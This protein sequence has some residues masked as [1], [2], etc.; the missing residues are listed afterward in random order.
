MNWMFFMA[1]E[2][3]DKIDVCKDLN[4]V[5]TIMGYVIL[6]IQVVVP[7]LLII[8]GMMT[9]A[10]AIMEKKEDAIKTAQ[11]LLIKKLIAAVIAFLVISVTKIVVDLV[12]N[13]SDNHWETCI[14]CALH[15]YHGDCGFNKATIDTEGSGDSGEGAGGSGEN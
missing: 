3:S 14:D 9:M 8:S 1:T 5:W 7:I 15:P 10:K 2:L 11:N 12:V 4:M 13:N 6:A